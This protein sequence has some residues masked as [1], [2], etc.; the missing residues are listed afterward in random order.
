MGRRWVWV[1][2]AALLGLGACAPRPRTQPLPPVVMAG[3]AMA[4]GVA[5]PA[6]GFEPLGAAESFPA[7]VPELVA[8]V[9]LRNVSK[10]HSFRWLW[11][12]PDDTLYYDSGE[13]YVQPAGYHPDLTSWHR[14]PVAGTQ[15]EA[16]P[17][18]WRVVIEMDKVE[19]TVLR[20][21]LEAEQQTV[22]AGG[23]GS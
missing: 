20:F 5:D 14:L 17:G 9:R 15:A 13:T 3:A 18:Q 4:T 12:A 22:G 16:L 10:I 19:L 23:Q 2:A 1:A 11:Y 8:W 21:S 7:R 6:G